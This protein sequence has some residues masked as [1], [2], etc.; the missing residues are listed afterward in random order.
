MCINTFTITC[1]VKK[2]LSPEIFRFP[3]VDVWSTFA[4]FQLNAIF[5]IDCSKERQTSVDLITHAL[6]IYTICMHFFDYV[7]NRLFSIAGT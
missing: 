1:F 4:F 6:N 2:N 5:N 3:T 7:I